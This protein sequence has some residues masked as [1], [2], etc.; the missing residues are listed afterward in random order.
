MADAT[1][2]VTGFSGSYDATT[3][4]ASG[5]AT[6]VLGEAL[7]G[8]DLGD[9]FTNAGTHSANWTFTDATGNYNDASGSVTIQIDKADAT[10]SVTGFSGSYDATAK[11][12]S[13]SATGVLG[14]ALAG[15]DLGD[16]FTNAGTHSANWTFTDV[17]GN[18]NNASGSVTIQ[19]DKADAAIVVNGF[20]GTYDAAAKGASGSATGVLG[21]TLAGLDLGGSFTNAGTQSAN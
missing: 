7:A 18:Y 6:S 3:K 1:V 15:L 5:S 11:G 13:G 21:E 8:L 14:E 10:V 12:A 16:S 19:I 20:S 17:T 4:E 2:S 9:S